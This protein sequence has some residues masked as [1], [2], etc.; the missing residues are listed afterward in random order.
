MEINEKLNFQ[1]SLYLK[2]LQYDRAAVCGIA[3]YFI[4]LQE[5]IFHI[6]KNICICNNYNKIK[7]VKYYHIQQSCQFC[8]YRLKQGSSR[9][10]N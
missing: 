2:Y 7:F 4:S 8:R 10:F 6:E 3:Q 5:F 1:L 9:K